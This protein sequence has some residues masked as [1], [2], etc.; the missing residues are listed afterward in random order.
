MQDV[1]DSQRQ[2]EAL[3]RPVSPELPAGSYLGDTSV[4][5]DIKDARRFDDPSESRGVWQRE[6]RTAR[7]DR[8][9]E[10][11]TRALAEETK[12]LQIAA[13]LVEA[14]VHTRGIEGVRD[15]LDLLLHLTRDFWD[16][17]Y[18][19]LERGPDFRAAPFNW[20]NEK[21]V[22]TLG[23]VTITRS[24]LSTDPSASWND[25]KRSLWLEQ[26]RSRQ[27]NDA[28]VLEEIE[29]S[30]TREDF[31]RLIA[32]T[33][34][35][36]FVERIAALEHA[37]QTL[38]ELSDYLDEH[39]DPDA[40]SVTRFRG[41]LEDMLSWMRTALPSALATVAPEAHTEH[42][43]EDVDLG[44]EDVE[45]SEED[46][47]LGDGSGDSVA[48]TAP[49]QAPSASGPISGREEAYRRLVEAARYLKSIEPHSPT[50][51]LVM[52]AVSWGDKT[53]EDLLRDFAGQ[54]FSVEALLA[55]L[56]MDE[57]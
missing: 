18:P 8:V 54:G 52:K 47:D 57:E 20:L 55:F 13:W 37:I 40:T 29:A 34:E 36:F 27:P 43:E 56:G 14:W 11:C 51:Y 6:L 16:D 46:V 24:A 7:W 50:P 33:P 23:L 35:S 3:L 38:R 44:E 42:S 1:V 5:D 30:T 25:W 45:L 19:S 9:E 48:E 32:G 21:V 53:L 41:T 4:Y 17:A 31:D 22:D 12:D 39:L 2:I 10:L 26:M 49:T 15:G 28:S